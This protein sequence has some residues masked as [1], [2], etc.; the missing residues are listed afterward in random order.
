MEHRPPLGAQDLRGGAL[1]TGNRKNVSI[2]PVLFALGQ[3]G[4]CGATVVLRTSY[5]PY[6]VRNRIFLVCE[7]GPNTSIPFY[8]CGADKVGCFFSS[9]KHIFTQ[10]W[11]ENPRL[12]ITPN[13]YA[14]KVERIKSQE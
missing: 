1:K 13:V 14:D 12:K 5:V 9:V 8:K 2:I 7:I 3:L 11:N 4:C 10:R 6:F